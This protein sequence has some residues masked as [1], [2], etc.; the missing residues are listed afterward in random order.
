MVCRVFLQYC[1]ETSLLID[2]LFCLALYLLQNPPLS[3]ADESVTGNKSGSRHRVLSEHVQFAF[4]TSHA[5]S[6]DS[7]PQ[8]IMFNSQLK[9]YVR[10]FLYSF[11]ES[12]IAARM[13]LADSG[14][15]IRQYDG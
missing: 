2:W 12:E 3:S 14:S 7:S 4:V 1:L 8:M 10:I 5:L 15:A 6:E 11:C 13:M 9:N